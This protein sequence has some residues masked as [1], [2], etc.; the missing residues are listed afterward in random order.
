MDYRMREDDVIY[1]LCVLGNVCD[2]CDF[3]PSKSFFCLVLQY[4][5]DFQYSICSIYNL[6]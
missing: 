1:E 2:L 5:I 3:I 4:C 6:T